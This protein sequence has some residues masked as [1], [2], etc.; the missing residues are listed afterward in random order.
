[1]SGQGREYRCELQE[2]PTGLRLLV[3]ADAD[4]R[5]FVAVIAG[6]DP[7]W[8]WKRLFVGQTMK[9]ERGRVLISAP[10]ESVLRLAGNTW[11]AFLDVC[12]GPRGT[13]RAATTDEIRAAWRG[14]C[15]INPRGPIPFYFC[16]EAEIMRHFGETVPVPP[17]V[18]REGRARL[19]LDE[20]EV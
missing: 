11:P 1:M 18:R 2:G 7:K 5:P 6:R 19:A 9:G 20:E 3:E 16:S 17:P 14:F 15:V 13:E 12:Y 8:K 4:C 10:V